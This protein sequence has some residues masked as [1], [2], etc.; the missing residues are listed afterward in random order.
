MNVSQ[1]WSTSVLYY[2]TY[3]TIQTTV[4]ALHSRVPAHIFMR[5]PDEKFLD[6]GFKHH[7]KK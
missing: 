1:K 2:T 5:Y 4:V 7:A 3:S 6:L